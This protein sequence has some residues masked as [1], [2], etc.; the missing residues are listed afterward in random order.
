MIKDKPSGRNLCRLLEEQPYPV[1]SPLTFHPCMET[2]YTPAGKVTT[3]NPLHTFDTA[4]LLLV[5]VLPTESVVALDEIL[6][7]KELFSSA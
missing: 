1:K 2:A 4:N 6:F 7:D 3:E 5:E